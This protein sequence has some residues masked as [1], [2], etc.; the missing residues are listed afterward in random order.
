MHPVKDGEHIS[1]LIYC[2][3]MKVNGFKRFAYKH[4]ANGNLNKHILQS[5]CQM[6]IN[7]IIIQFNCTLEGYINHRFLKM[8]VSWIYK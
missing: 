5:N 7:K 4:I 8:S 6:E 3:T 2:L 1:D